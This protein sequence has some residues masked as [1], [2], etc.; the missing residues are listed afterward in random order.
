MLGMTRASRT[1]FR[2]LVSAA[3]GLMLLVGGGGLFMLGT[4]GFGDSDGDGLP[5]WQEQMVGTDPHDL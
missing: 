1:F 5:D 2:V 4:G 3:L